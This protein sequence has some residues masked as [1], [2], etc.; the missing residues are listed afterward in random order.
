VHA[1][2]TYAWYNIKVINQSGENMSLTQILNSIDGLTEEQLI[3]LNNCVVTEIKAARKRKS[4]S[5]KSTLSVGDRV[6]F[7]GRNRGRNAR[8]FTVEGDITKIKRKNAEVRADSGLTWNVPIT[9][10]AKLAS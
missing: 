3:L 8:R 1:N 6:S 4:A 5:I 9:Q 7:T 10:L 2:K